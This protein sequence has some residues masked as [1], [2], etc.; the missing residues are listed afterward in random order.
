[1]GSKKKTEKILTYFESRDDITRYTLYNA[2]TS[3]A[4]HEAGKIREE[5]NLQ[6]KA[7]KILITEKTRLNKKEWKDEE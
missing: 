4:T 6:R 1:M 3:Y 5:E 2:I 7:E